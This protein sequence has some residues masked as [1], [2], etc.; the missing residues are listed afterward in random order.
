[1]YAKTCLFNIFCSQSITFKS[2]HLGGEQLNQTAQKENG[3]F[4]QLFFS[5]LVLYTTEQ[6]GYT[7][8]AYTGSPFITALCQ[9]PKSN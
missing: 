2:R 6:V 4:D 3:F 9:S 7:G 8:I 5:K 1:M